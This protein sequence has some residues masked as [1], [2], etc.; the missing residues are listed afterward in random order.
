MTPS[1]E[2]LSGS[3]EARKS[4]FVYNTWLRKIEIEETN[5]AKAAGRYRQL[6]QDLLDDYAA[7]ER[8]NT[9]DQFHADLI[10][11]LKAAIEAKTVELGKAM[12]S[13]DGCLSAMMLFQEIESY[14]RTIRVLELRELLRGRSLISQPSPLNS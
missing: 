9:R 2:N 12:C 6:A 3:Q 5:P 7:V 10:A 4:A 14:E 11:E 13:V 1:A 8:L